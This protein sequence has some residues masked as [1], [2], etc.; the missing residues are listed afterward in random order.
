MYIHICIYAYICILTKSRLTPASPRAFMFGVANPGKL[1]YGKGGNNV[2]TAMCVCTDGREA[3]LY[4]QGVH[5]EGRIA[6]DCQHQ[7]S[8]PES[9]CRVWS[10]PAQRCAHCHQFMLGIVTGEGRRS[11]CGCDCV[12][13]DIERGKTADLGPG[14]GCK[15][16]DTRTV[17]HQHDDSRSPLRFTE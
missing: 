9:E 7:C 12:W 13:T 3:L 17:K 10:Q 11:H 1:G 15:G 5:F 14:C 8:V 16:C 4:A 2:T 6:K